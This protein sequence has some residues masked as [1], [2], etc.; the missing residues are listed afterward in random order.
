ML[1]AVPNVTLLFPAATV[2]ELAVVKAGQEI[3]RTP[4]A[5]FPSAR[6]TV[7]LIVVRAGV[8][9]CIRVT[10]NAPNRAKQKSRHTGRLV[11]DISPPD[12]EVALVLVRCFHVLLQ[13]L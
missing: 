10:K 4:A 9:D 3:S 7:S 5:G 12:L 8:C 13:K 6:Y 1:P 11:C 2:A